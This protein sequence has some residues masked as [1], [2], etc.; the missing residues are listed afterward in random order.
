[1]VNVSDTLTISGVAERPYQMLNF[2]AFPYPSNI[3]SASANPFADGGQASYVNVKAKHIVLE[4]GGII[5]SLTFGGGHAGNAEVIADTITMSGWQ[6]NGIL[7]RSGI[8]NSSTNSE[9]YA[10]QAGNIQV[11]ANKITINDGGAINTSAISAGGGNININIKDRLHLSKQ[12]RITTSV[13][14]G[15]GSGGNITIEEPQFIILNR[16]QIKA[17]ADEG[18]GGNIRIVAEQLIKSSDSLIDA[19]SRLGVDGNVTVDSPEESVSDSLVILSGDRIDAAAMMKKPCSEYVAEEDRS[20]F[21][22]NPINGVRPAPH[23]RQGSNVLLAPNVPQTT[24][25]RNTSNA[26]ASSLTECQKTTQNTIPL[27]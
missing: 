20:H 13:E 15:E 26:M 14:S 18:H 22:V 16:G 1:M 17:Q 5:G 4:A 9:S 24:T 10:G 3:T 8:D 6:D 25:T 21:Y 11:T 7:Y 19:S 12:G 27:F 23:D 2:P